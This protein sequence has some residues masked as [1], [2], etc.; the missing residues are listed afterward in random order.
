MDGSEDEH[1]TAT[2]DDGETNSNAKRSTFCEALLSPESLPHIKSNKPKK[3][4]KR[5]EHKEIEVHAEEQAS[6]VTVSEPVC[7]E[8]IVIPL[9]VPGDLPSNRVRVVK[10]PPQSLPYVQ[11]ISFPL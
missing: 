6:E 9:V 1:H 2:G 10:G 3:V 7:S 4:R 11:N 8:P 5:K